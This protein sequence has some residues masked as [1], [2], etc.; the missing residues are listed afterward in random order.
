MLFDGHA[1]GQGLSFG[2][3]EKCLSPLCDKGYRYRLIFRRDK[4]ICLYF[5]GSHLRTNAFEMPPR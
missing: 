2:G 4:G 1:A 5:N 3:I